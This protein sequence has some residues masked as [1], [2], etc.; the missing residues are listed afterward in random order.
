MNIEYV[1]GET[2]LGVGGYIEM[3]NYKIASLYTL[4]SNAPVINY[5]VFD[6]N[7][8]SGALH[9]KCLIYANDGG[10]PGQLLYQTVEVNPV[11]VGWNIAPFV[12]PVSLIAGSYWL[13]VIH[14]E[15]I[16][17]GA[18]GMTNGSYYNSDTYSNGPTDP[19]GS[20]SWMTWRI[21]IYAAKMVSNK[22]NVMIIT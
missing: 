8:Y 18:T 7:T 13:G 5:L 22:G 9:V 2:H 20:G 16:N 3:W 4:N 14:D 1:F 11:V 17:I 15:M 12:A 10:V 21:A 19:F 6:S